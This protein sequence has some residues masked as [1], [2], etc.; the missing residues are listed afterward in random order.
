MLAM[1]LFYCR[2]F[3]MKLR[4]LT[5]KF[6]FCF[7]FGCAGLM[8]SSPV[9]AAIVE[10]Q[11]LGFGT[12]ALQDNDGAY[13]IIIAPTGSI[14]AN[15]HFLFF[16]DGQEGQYDVS[17]FPAATPLIINVSVNPL[18]HGGG[19]ESFTISAPAVHPASPVTDGSGNASFG[20]GA[21]LTTSGTGTM[22]FDGAFNGSVTI[23]VN[24]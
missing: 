22:Y 17:G 2:L 3:Y 14:A 11:S 1:G 24:F 15:S 4:K 16:A 12:F 20:L 18:N 21:T 23:T 19:G 10:T 13:S 5:Q 6:L 7:V 8:I 9:S